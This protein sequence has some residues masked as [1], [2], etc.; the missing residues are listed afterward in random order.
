MTFTAAVPFAGYA[1]WA[2]LRRTQAAQTEAIA[3]SPVNARDE[4]YFREKIGSI[5]TAEALVDDRRLLRVALTAFGLEADLDSRFFIRKVLEDGT[6]NTDALSNRLADSRYRDFSA[7]FGFG[8]FATPRTVLSDF[9]DR[10]LGPWR[11]RQ[12]EAS[13]G[14]QDETLRLALNAARELPA[15]AAKGSSETSKWFAVMGNAPLRR[16][17]EG[18]L[19][20]PSSFGVLDIDKQREMLADK[21]ERAFGAPTVSQF[22]DP[23]QVEAL[24]RR[25]LARA[26]AESFVAGPGTAALTLLQAG[27]ASLAALRAG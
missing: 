15:L 1:G 3:A 24:V 12:F 11:A 27:Q 25:Y 17:F 8:D 13:V 16:V 22:T 10:I 2:F 21:A 9:P 23:A 26:Q 4:A 5:R 7:A 20:L 6:L 18:A 19:G 14:Q